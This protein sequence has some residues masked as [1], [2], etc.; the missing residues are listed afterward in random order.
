ML[1]NKK[2]E[3]CGGRTA[4]NKRAMLKYVPFEM[5]TPFT[6]TQESCYLQ[7]KPNDITLLPIAL[8]M[9]YL[10]SVIRDLSRTV[11]WTYITAGSTILLRPTH[12]S[13]LSVT[14]LPS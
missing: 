11:V 1:K 4:Q 12:G 3:G 2:V 7:T 10:P 9:F 6:M 13:E 5:E 8:I 14:Q